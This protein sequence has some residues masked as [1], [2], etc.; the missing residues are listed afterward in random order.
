MM[1][2]F[3]ILPLIFCLTAQAQVGPVKGKGQEQSTFQTIERL[4]TPNSGVTVT[5]DKKVLLE[6]DKD[7]LLV[8]PGFE[9][10]TFSTGWTVN[11]GTATVDTTN[12]YDGAKS[13]S[14]SL[15][16]VTG[17]IITQCVTPTGQ[18]LG[19]NM[20]H[21]M[22]VKTTLNNL[23]VCAVQG[24]TEVQCVAVG[25]TD[26]WFDAFATSVAQAGAQC[27][28]L[29]STSSATGTVK[30][31]SGFVGE[32]RAPTFSYTQP[33]NV[34]NFVW[35]GSLTATHDTDVLF[36]W[37]GATQNKLEN[38]THS[39]GVF[40]VTVPGDYQ[41]KFCPRLDTNAGSASLMR[42]MIAKVY[43][44]SSSTPLDASGYVH[45]LAQ[46]NIN[47]GGEPSSGFY[48]NPPPCVIN[49][50]SYALNDTI[51]FKGY[52]ANG[53]G[54][55][56]S[57]V[58]GTLE[59]NYLPSS[60]QQAIAPSNQ[61][62]PTTT[63]LTSGS[64]TYTVP[65][66][67]VYLEVKLQA[68]GGGASG[69]DTDNG[70]GGAGGG[71]G[72]CAI[73]T[74]KNLAASY[75]Y[76]VGSAGTGTVAANSPSNGSAGGNSTF[77]LSTAVGGGGGQA[78]AA[79]N[80]GDG[81]GG[82]VGA[83]ATGTISFGQGGDTVLGGAGNSQGRFGGGGGCFGGG[84]RANVAT[85]ANG[86]A[87]ATNS[88]GGGSGGLPGT[89]TG[90]NGAAGRIEI[91]EYYGINVP[92]IV[93]SISAIDPNKYFFFGGATVSSGAVVSNETG[94][95]WINGNCTNSPTGTTTCT[96]N[97][98]IFPTGIV[99]ICVATL[100]NNFDQ[101]IQK[102]TINNTQFQFLQRRVSDGVGANTGF[103]VLCYGPR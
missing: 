59:I 85:S 25:N 67:A 44:N 51:R 62:S 9:H 92:I 87:G 84:G 83:D 32:N 76:A 74:L 71:G 77:G 54:T 22:R 10:S 98:G 17:D 63:V 7:N 95:D 26:T 68:A 73:L 18:K 31:D 99:P 48:A 12:F 90:G 80:G 14:I 52:Q 79:G 75:S 21:T 58:G 36:T 46:N 50:S 28:K 11:A 43:K 38:M 103:N 24:S 39:S 8:N 65:S 96:I 45:G 53:S 55:N 101:G 5:G 88:G 30:V 42:G 35:T 20:K 4:E 91:T 81:G 16:A 34:V 1:K 40:T 97:T 78:P 27:V 70:I 100:E 94:G 61:K 2:I 29:K 89:G 57:W 86:N 13:A 47:G 23:Q 3:R 72:G 66:G 64:G 33:R 102:G 41:T 60:A 82:T 37:S 93:G 49:T 19:T 15:S 6:S 69:A 56:F